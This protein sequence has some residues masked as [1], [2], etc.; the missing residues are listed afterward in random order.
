MAWPRNTT[1]AVKFEVG[2]KEGRERERWVKE[3]WE[4]GG[5]RRE[6]ANKCVVVSIVVY[7]HHFYQTRKNDVQ[8]KVTCFFF[9][10]APAS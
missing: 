3:K 1:T 9:W 10:K 2:R 8:R 7:K 5:G 4:E 6:T